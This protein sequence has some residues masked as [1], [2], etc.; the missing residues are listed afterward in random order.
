MRATATAWAIRSRG[1]Y[2]FGV[3]SLRK[4]AIAEA[5]RGSDKPWRWWKRKYG[6]RAVKIEIREVAR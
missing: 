5:V 4:E 3:K 2:L 1:G 6:L